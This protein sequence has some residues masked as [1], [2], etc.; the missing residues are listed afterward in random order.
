MNQNVIHGKHIDLQFASLNDKKLIFEMLVSQDIKELMFNDQYLAP[1]WD[2]FDQSETDELFL[3]SL[4]EN[5]NYLIILSQKQKIG[6]ISFF[7][8]HGKI[9][10]A[11]LDIW[12]SSLNHL[13]QGIGT[14]ALKLLMNFLETKINIHCFL[15]RPWVKNIRALKAYQK[16]G[17]YE[18]SNEELK[19]FILESDF[20][21]YGQGDY[22][23][24]T[25]NLLY[26][27]IPI[28]PS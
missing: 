27:N 10:C 22:L 16:C 17:F 6:A 7:I 12:I 15:I 23:E 19:D 28:N 11:E 21:K 14:E 1:T 13:N 24:E 18:I 25:I 9:K 26:Q 4:N 2:E 20:E 8:H 3:G 5:G